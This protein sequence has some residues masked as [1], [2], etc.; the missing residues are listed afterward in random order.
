MDDHVENIDF[1]SYLLDDLLDEGF[2]FAANID[3]IR[4][5]SPAKVT[6]A[7]LTEREASMFLEK[8]F[9][10][11]IEKN[12]SQDSGSVAHSVDAFFEDF[13]IELQL[14]QES[15]I[16]AKQAGESIAKEVEIIEKVASVLRDY[17]R[18]FCRAY[19][20]YAPTPARNS[21]FPY[22]TGKYVRS[23]IMYFTNDEASRNRAL[24]KAFSAQDVPSS[25]EE[26]IF[27]QSYVINQLTQ[28]RLFYRDGDIKKR[29]NKVLGGITIENIASKEWNGDDF[30]YG[31][32]IVEREGW[33]KKDGA[34]KPPYK[35]F[36]HA[37]EYAKA[38]SG[39]IIETQL[40]DDN[41]QKHEYDETVLKY[42]NQY[43]QKLPKS[44]GR[45]YRQH[46]PVQWENFLKRIKGM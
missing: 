26:L 16:K 34:R 42:F 39:G 4:E 2:D 36:Q 1:Y 20:M 21:S 25:G 41:R 3:A 24:V 18:N 45:E 6:E 27:G 46:A 11:S 8:F 29:I 14:R 40:H 28:Y 38:Q 7:V 22:S 9:T 12:L 31:W 32:S 30:Y 10:L 23:S 5:L 33:K 19:I 43:L 44:F 37:I 15:I 17:I 35:P 13:F